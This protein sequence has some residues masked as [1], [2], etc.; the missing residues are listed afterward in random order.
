MEVE[1]VSLVEPVPVVVELPTADESIP[2]A[3]LD[4]GE[5]VVSDDVLTIVESAVDVSVIELA[6][7][8]LEAE[9]DPEV[10]CTDVAFHPPKK[11][12]SAFTVTW[13]PT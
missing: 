7:E 2:V 10:A 4:V 13:F 12:L 8:S 11:D 1:L 3:V 9:V 5:V 6:A